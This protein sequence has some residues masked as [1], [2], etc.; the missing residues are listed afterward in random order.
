MRKNIKQFVNIVAETLPIQE[1]IYE[2]GSL[3]VPGQEDWA[4]LRPI[5][6]G[7]H[8]IGVDMREG[9]GVDVVLNLHH[10]DLPGQSV[11]TVLCLDTLEHVACPHLALQEIYR[12][13][14][15]SGMVVISSVMDLP[16]HDYPYDYWRFT[17]EAFKLLLEPF[18]GI[19]VGY[20]GKKILPHTV[21]GIGIKNEQP[22]IL[23]FK[24]KYDQWHLKQKYTLK[25]CLRAATPPILFEN[26]TKTYSY[27]VS[28]KPV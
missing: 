20:A 7:Y 19:F 25:N 21:V 2:F 4:N 13:L 12:I 16:I 15:P 14:K 24:N 17:P 27:L 9:P 23:N 1:P 6:Q 11:G 26:L 5:F 10:I 28:K 8:Y 3:Q 22:D 18:T